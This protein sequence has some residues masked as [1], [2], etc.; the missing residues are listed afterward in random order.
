MKDSIADNI[1][2]EN[3]RGYDAIAEKFSSTR[4]FPW[5]EFEFFKQ[6]VKNGDNVLDAGC[7]NGRLYEFLK[8]SGI[9]Y[10]G[11]DSSQNL[12]KIAQTNY[13]AGNFQIGNI[14]KL[15]YPDNKFDVLFC[16]ATLHHIPSGKLRHQVVSELQRVLKPNGYLIMTNW[17][18]LNSKWWPTLMKFTIKKIFTNNQLDFGDVTKPWKN[19]YGQ[20]QTERYLHAFTKSQIKNLLINAFKI[21]KQFYT[22]R[23]TNTNAFIGFNLVTIA[24]KV[25]NN[26]K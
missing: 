16:V 26:H 10:F 23:D 8:D 20:V 4:K 5:Q 18:L 25:E 13:P 21:E 7:G 9:N 24:K 15:P 6:Y 14:T 3:T 11:I 22:K 12:I 2:K 17:N 1:L 19:N